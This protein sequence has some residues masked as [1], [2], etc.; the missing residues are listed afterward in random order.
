LRQLAA[1]HVPAGSRIYIV[2]HSQ[3][4]AAATLVH[5]F[6]HYAAQSGAGDD[7]FSLEKKRFALKSYAFAQPKPGNQ[8]FAADFAS[9]TQQDDSAIVVNNNIDPIPQAPMT[10]QS[11]GDIV[12]DLPNRSSLIKVL[13]CLASFSNGSIRLAG[14]LVEP[15]VRKD[16]AGYGPYFQWNRLAAS[17]RNETPDGSLDFL[18]VGHVYHVY[19]T[20][21]EPSDAFL[22]HHA[23][24]YRNLLKSQLN[25]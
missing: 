22:Q 5:A 24:T 11:L 15:I 23:W 17:G 14:R 18:A 20:P 10:L 1:P 4:A 8:D 3:G 25:F 19:G 9:Y 2:G 12:S 7:L 21:G 16:A 6:L 13:A